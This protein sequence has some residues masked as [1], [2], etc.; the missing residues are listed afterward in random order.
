[1]QA[2][3]GRNRSMTPRTS[4]QPSRK[5]IFLRM[6]GMCGQRERFPVLTTATGWF[7]LT[8]MPSRSAAGTPS[9][10]QALAASFWR[11]GVS[12]ASALPNPAR[13]SR[14]RYPRTMRT[15]ALAGRSVRIWSP[16]R[17]QP[18][19]TAQTSGLVPRPIQMP[20]QFS[21]GNAS[22][23]VTFGDNEVNVDLAL[24]KDT[25][26]S[27]R[28]RLQFRAEMFNLFNHTN[29]ATFPAELRSRRPWAIYQR[30]ELPPVAACTQTALLIWKDPGALSV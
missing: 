22:R 19:L 2:I 16:I 12:P 20:P 15:S 17:T 6:F 23:N 7:S 21:F 27:E 26:L 24:H 25:S 3:R 1:M 28:T 29:F 5:Q 8:R 10:C 14:S 9:I 11:V 30:T 18:P 13:R 4:G